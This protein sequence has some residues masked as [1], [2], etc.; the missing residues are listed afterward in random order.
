V[1]YYY[2]DDP[3]AMMK[4]ANGLVLNEFDAKDGKGFATV[5]LRLK[6][7]FQNTN[8]YTRHFQIDT[9]GFKGPYEQTTATK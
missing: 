2:L 7:Q 9:T 1:I 4:E 5:A 8:I 3:Q 6:N